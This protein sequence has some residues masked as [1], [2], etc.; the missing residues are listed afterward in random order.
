[1][2]GREIAEGIS[3]FLGLR[4]RI[5]ALR[6]L[7]NENEIPEYAVRPLRDL[8]HRMS[9]CQA[10][11]RARRQGV[12]T[13]LLLQDHWCAEPLIGYGYGEPPAF[14]LEGGNRYPA[15]ASTKEA[16][17]RWAENMPKL[18]AGAYAG[19]LCGPWDGTDFEPDALILYCDPAQLTHLLI[20]ANWIDGSDVVSQ[21][22]GHAA[23]VYAAVPALKEHRF[24]VAV[25]CIGDRKRAA[26][27]DNEIIF[28]CP[29]EKAEALLEGFLQCSSTQA[30][31]PIQQDVSFEYPLAP[32]YKKIG[33]M[34]GIDYERGI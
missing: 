21:L 11:S 14:F 12:T 5:I 4:T 30:G 6:M 16:G 7:R 1:M 17:R 31:F 29:P 24:T 23:C 13:A 26:A 27:Q 9:L 20:S 33:E 34:M 3:R 28:T 2:T 19:I 32:A 25:P 10:F 18:P 15:S 22:S 8:G